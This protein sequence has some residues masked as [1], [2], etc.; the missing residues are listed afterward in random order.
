MTTARQESMQAHRIRRGRREKIMNRYCW[1]VLCCCLLAATSA[2][3]ADD[4]IA[5]CT[6]IAD[7]TSRLACYDR[8][9][10]YQA[11]E[12]A[13][14]TARPA[15]RPPA[16]A[17]SEAA[18]AASAGSSA[19]SFLGRM[20]ELSGSAKNGTFRF[21]PYQPNYFMF[22]R[23]SSRPNAQPFLAQPRNCGSPSPAGQ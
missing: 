9:A 3:A 18:A 22:W 16:A 2:R 5:A 4:G 8:A 14:E 7:A 10:G 6:G 23:H 19:G 15:E 20:W 11:A 1:R 21:R 13:S 12:R 17:D